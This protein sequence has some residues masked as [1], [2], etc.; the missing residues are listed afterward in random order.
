MTQ[1]QKSLAKEP[2]NKLIWK[3]SIPAIVG[4]VFASL[5]N[6]IDTIF[7]GQTVGSMGIAGLAISFPIMGIYGALAVML[8]T[9]SASIISRAL[10][11]KDKVK[12]QK[13]LGNF[14]SLAIL[15]SVVLTA[16]GLV[17]LETLLRA[18]GASEMILPYAID[19]ARIIIAGIIVFMFSI[20]PSDIIRAQGNARYAMM[21]MILP[22]ILN[23]VLDYFFIIAWN[24]GISGAA[25]ATVAGQGLGTLLAI[26]YFISPYNTIRTKLQDLVLHFA[27]VKEII[28]I[29]ASSFTRSVVKVGTMVILNHSLIFYGGEIAV[30]AFGILAK[31]VVFTMMPMVGFVHGLQPVLGYNYGAKNYKRAKKSIINVII[32]ITVYSVVLFVPLVIFPEPLVKIFTNEKDLIEL[33]KDMIRIVFILLP[34]MGFQ[35]I[36]SGIYQ[37]MGKAKMA[38]F[39]SLLRRAILLIPLVIILPIFFGL[40]GIFIA[41]PVADFFGAFINGYYLRKEFILLDNGNVTQKENVLL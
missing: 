4:L 20:S 28:V 23:I 25:L 37:T 3:Q 26:T 15:V 36:A 17:Y 24:W 1:T 6:V 13:I 35:H 21:I 41:Y 2:I 29:G 38:I 32:K 12:A 9:G 22:M 10:G 16:L 30:A 11:A 18:F 34:I 40:Y 5:Y 33:S 14:L 39:L 8:G 19:Y 27:L 7:I 31:V